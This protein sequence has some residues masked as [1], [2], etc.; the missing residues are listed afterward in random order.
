MRI[1]SVIYTRIVSYYVIVYSAIASRNFAN[2]FSII[3]YVINVLQ[4]FYILY[5]AC[6]SHVNDKVI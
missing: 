2:V 6:I 4:M 3:V 5:V 1:K